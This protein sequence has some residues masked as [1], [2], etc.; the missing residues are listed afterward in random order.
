MGPNKDHFAGQKIKKWY[1]GQGYTLNAS[2]PDEILET[3]VSTLSFKDSLTHKYT[4]NFLFGD[5]FNDM[6][7]WLNIFYSNKTD[8]NLYDRWS[9]PNNTA[10]DLFYYD[11]NTK[12]LL[13]TPGVIIGNTSLK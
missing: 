4:L 1:E 8:A 6:E 9:F 12:I 10:M 13:N 7:V 2:A 5:E 11:N 3:G